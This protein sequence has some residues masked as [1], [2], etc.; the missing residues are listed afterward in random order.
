MKIE[1]TKS[2]SELIE[3]SLEELLNSDD[4]KNLSVEAKNDMNILVNKFFNL[5]RSF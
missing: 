1:L 3:Y 4:F 2:Q 5:T